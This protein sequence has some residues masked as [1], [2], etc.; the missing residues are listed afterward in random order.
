MMP[1]VVIRPEPGASAT[2]AA[3]SAL[4]LDAHGYPLFEIVPH[5]WDALDPDT[6]DALLIGSANTLRHGGETLLRFIAKPVYAVGETTAAAARSAG[7]T[8]AATARGGLQAVMSQIAPQHR[9][10]LRP[11]GDV[12]VPLA[13]PDHCTVI[14]RVVYASQ[15][16]AMPDPL[17]RLLARPA[18]VALH[19]AEA[20]RHFR[21]E[22]ERLGLDRIR[23][24]IAAMGKRIAAAAGPGWSA[25]AVAEQADNA[26]LLALAGQLCK[27]PD[28][29]DTG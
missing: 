27:K 26:S 10:L 20:A 9:R 6:I 25:C 29:Q 14:E 23:L 22:C 15:P 12:R 3:A 13:I 24:T 17:A 11:G 18:V 4:G 19:S 28:D 21:A 7:F 8:V 2:L 16:L 5:D 1:L